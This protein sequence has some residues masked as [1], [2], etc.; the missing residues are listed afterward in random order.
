MWLIGTHENQPLDLPRPDRSHYVIDTVPD[1]VRVRNDE[2]GEST[3]Y[4]VMQIWVDPKFPDAWQDKALLD[5][6]ETGIIALIR[7]DS[8]NGF[9]LCPPSRSGTGKWERS[10]RQEVSNEALRAAQLEARLKFWAQQ[11]EE[12]G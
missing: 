11:A 5:L 6:L 12:Q 9:A 3:Q 1:I 7:Y 8:S 2:T 4:D 10:V